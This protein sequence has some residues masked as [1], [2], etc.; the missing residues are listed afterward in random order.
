MEDTSNKLA[1]I[2]DDLT[3]ACDTACQF[4]LYGFR[5]EVVDSAG[6]GERQPQFL[7]C[8]S[9]SRKEEAGTAHQKIFDIASALLRAH[10]LPFYKKLDSTLKGPWSAELAGMAKAVKPEIVV[11]APAFPAWGRTTVEGI[12]CVQGR[13]VWESRF[14]A[15]PHGD[16]PPAAEPGNLVHTLQ[17]QFGNHV[18][19]FRRA[20]LKKGAA[21]VAKEMEAARFQGF[22]F[23]VFDAEADEDLKTVVLAGCRLERRILWAGSGGLA[24]CL[25][26][27]WGLRTQTGQSKFHLSCLQTLV[28]NGSFNPANQEQLACLERGGTTVCW[29]EDEDAEN[30]NRCHRKVESLLGLIERGRDAALSV[31]LNKPIRSAAHLQ[32]LQDAL[33]FAAARCLPAD[34]NIGLILIGGDTAIKLYRNLEA[35]AIRIEGE[36]QPGVPHGRWVGGRLN[37]QP[38]VTKAG[39]FGQTDTLAKAAAFLKGI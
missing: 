29:I 11:V 39:G 2:A 38:L 10:Y 20:A 26:L 19:H 36:V 8:N 6:W 23:L 15:F 5:P 24:R 25:P 28:I 13:P 1:V 18:R 30:H 31:R 21:A 14:H 16:A 4:A 32:R 17:A 33:Q 12:Q 7:V 34:G 9:E 27:G 37:E 3:G 35:A 22:P